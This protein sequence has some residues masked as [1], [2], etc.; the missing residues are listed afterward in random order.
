MIINPK[1]KII[2]ID[3]TEHIFDGLGIAEEFRR[4]GKQL[5]EYI[6]KDGIKK[7]ESSQAVCHQ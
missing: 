1:D 6:D 3:Y 7:R 5:A 2:T 4:L